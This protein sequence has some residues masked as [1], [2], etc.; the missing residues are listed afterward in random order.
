MFSKDPFSSSAL[1]LPL[2]TQH[3]SLRRRKDQCVQPPAASYSP[4]MERNEVLIHF[5][6]LLARFTHKFVKKKP[7]IKYGFFLKCGLFIKL[8]SVKT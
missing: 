7:S 8:S 4:I 3:S 1:T 2:E 5:V 6:H